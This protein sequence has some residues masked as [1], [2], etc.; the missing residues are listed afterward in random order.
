MR[1]GVRNHSKCD[2]SGT[3]GLCLK[4]TS[5]LIMLGLAAAALAACSLPWGGGQ[6]PA[7]PPSTPSV[8]QQQDGTPTPRVEQLGHADLATFGIGTE[9]TVQEWRGVRLPSRMSMS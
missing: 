5:T 1:G 4:R 2:D 9:I 8:A 6:A 7:P 3:L